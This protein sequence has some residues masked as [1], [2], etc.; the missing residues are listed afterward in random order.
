MDSIDNRVIE[1]KAVIKVMDILSDTKVVMPCFSFNDKTP[2][3]DGFL[4]VYSSSEMKKENLIGKANVQIKG[5][6][7]VITADRCS[8]SIE[9]AHLINYRNAGG[10]IF[11]YVSID[12]DK[13]ESIVYYSL[14]HV[15]D[16]NEMLEKAGPHK[17]LSIELRKFP[18]KNVNE[19]VTIL[20]N[21][22]KDFVRQSSFVK[23]NESLVKMKASGQPIRSVKS[24]L[25][26]IGLHP[27]EVGVYISTHPQYLYAELEGMD[28]P[29]PVDKVDNL[30]YTEMF[31][32]PVE[33]NGKQYYDCF[34]MVTE[35]GIRTIHIGVTISIVIDM[36]E[37]CSIGYETKGTLDELIRDTEFLLD[38]FSFGSCSFADKVLKIP[39]VMAKSD[40]LARRMD[41]LNDLKT[42]FMSIG[43]EGTVGFTGFGEDDF[44]ALLEMMVHYNQHMPIAYDGEEYYPCRVFR[45]NSLYLLF[46]I[47]KESNGECYLCTFYDDYHLGYYEPNDTYKERKQI[48]SHCLLLQTDQLAYAN[49]LNINLIYSYVTGKTATES[50]IDE[51][52]DLIERTLKA[53]DMKTNN[54]MSLLLLADRLCEWVQSLRTTPYDQLLRFQIVKRNRPLDNN[55]ISDIQAR[56]DEYD[57]AYCRCCCYVLLNDKENVTKYYDM[58]MDDEKENFRNSSIS[59]L[60]NLVL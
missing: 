25:D 37:Q 26:F 33:I 60:I 52:C 28:V 51:V 29:V 20:R 35:K 19:I 6:G 24:D 4:E 17:S 16:L 14:L 12:F 53:S 11:F 55:E 39:A 54:S 50:Y 44:A 5:T 9:V 36:D 43:V 38:L 56:I 23:K 10:C 45:I 34:S 3:F 32:C 22:L 21:A 2:S 18:Q 13:G 59:G 40:L 47:E 41:C 15:Y 49:N 27:L 42:F 58:L 48:A 1:L 7:S 30:I 8:Y 57:D 46:W 31:N